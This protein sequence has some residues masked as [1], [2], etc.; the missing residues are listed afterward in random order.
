MNGVVEPILVV[1][2]LTLALLSL[3]SLALNSYLSLRFSTTTVLSQ[4]LRMLFVSE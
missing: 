3:L 1:E 4:N 2:S